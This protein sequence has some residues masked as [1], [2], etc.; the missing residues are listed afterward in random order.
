MRIIIILVH[1][2]KLAMAI[3]ATVESLKK[4]NLKAFVSNIIR[5]ALEVVTTIIDFRQISG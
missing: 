2:V 5:V 3:K 4:K 1:A